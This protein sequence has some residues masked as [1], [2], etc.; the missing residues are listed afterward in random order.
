[1]LCPFKYQ[2]S[3][4][5]LTL[6][7]CAVWLVNCCICSNYI[8]HE[9]VNNWE[10]ICFSFV[11][12]VLLFSTS[13]MEHIKTTVFLFA[14]AF[15]ILICF[16]NCLLKMVFQFNFLAAF[17]RGLVPVLFQLRFFLSSFENKSFVSSTLLYL[18]L[19]NYV[20]SSWCC[21]GVQISQINKEETNQGY[22][23]E[24]IAWTPKGETTWEMTSFS[25][26]HVCM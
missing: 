18:W 22:K 17:R 2:L 13:L 23:T 20:K 1:M 26:K 14:A 15:P 6:I 10:N 4:S 19:L 8:S 7:D 9:E 5:F 24:R 25:Q 16:M 3:I 21:S 12:S 11:L